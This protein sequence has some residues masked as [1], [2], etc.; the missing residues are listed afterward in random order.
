MGIPNL[1]PPT[2]I[3][4]AYAA[5]ICFLA[6]QFIFLP[7]SYERSTKQHV[8]TLCKF[9]GVISKMHSDPLAESAPIYLDEAVSTCFEQQLLN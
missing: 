3:Q 2:L 5:I 7:N 6:Y 4:L 8:R 1:R 9:V